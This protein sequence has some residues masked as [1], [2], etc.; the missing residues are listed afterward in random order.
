[1]F[2]MLFF[3]KLIKSFRFGIE[4]FNTN[5]CCKILTLKLQLESRFFLHISIFFSSYLSKTRFWPE[6]ENDKKDKKKL[7]EFLSRLQNYKEIDMRQFCF[8]RMFNEHFFLIAFNRYFI[9][10][11]KY[12]SFLIS[13]ISEFIMIFLNLTLLFNIFRYLPGHFYSNKIYMHKK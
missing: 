8:A 11:I 2:Y 13:C 5:C 3:F 12:I 4:I 1:M 6:C 9:W 10:T 7:I